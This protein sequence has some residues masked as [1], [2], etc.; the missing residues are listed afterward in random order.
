[1]TITDSAFNASFV[2]SAADWLSSGDDLVAIKT[3]GSRDSRL[4]KVQDP[5]ARSALISFAYAINLVLVPLLV[6]AFGLARSYRRKRLAKDEALIKAGALS[7][8]RGPAAAPKEAGALSAGQRREA[9]SDDRE[10]GK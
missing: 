2:V 9:E 7:A 10:G 3:R 1:M 4:S 6:V 8:G 5:E